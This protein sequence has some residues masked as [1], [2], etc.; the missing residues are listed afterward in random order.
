MISNISLLSLVDSC[1]FKKKI[2][3]DGSKICANHIGWKK[4]QRLE[5]WRN[6]LVARDFKSSSSSSE[7]NKYILFFK[8]KCS[9]NGCMHPI[10]SLLLLELIDGADKVENMQNKDTISKNVLSKKRK[11]HFKKDTHRW[12]W[13]LRKLWRVRKVS[14]GRALEKLPSQIEYVAWFSP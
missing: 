2:H 10:I 6:C 9:H 3:V 4:F 14:K 1:L 8:V 13:L 12:R 5:H 11:H 7:S